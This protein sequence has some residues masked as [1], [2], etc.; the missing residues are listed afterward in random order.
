MPALGLG[1][2][3]SSLFNLLH[4]RLGLW[5][6]GVESVGFEELSFESQKGSLKGSA[7]GRQD[8]ASETDSSYSYRTPKCLHFQ[9][10]QLTILRSPKI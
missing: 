5:D 3:V 6:L 2:E 4:S 10:H 1:F 7:K 8:T 9:R